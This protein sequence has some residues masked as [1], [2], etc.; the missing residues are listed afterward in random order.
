MKVL[1]FVQFGESDLT[2]LHVEQAGTSQVGERTI[3]RPP[4]LQPI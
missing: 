1:D 3:G 4:T 2:S